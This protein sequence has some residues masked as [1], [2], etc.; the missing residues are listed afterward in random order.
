MESTPSS[1]GF[2]VFDDGANACESFHLT[3]LCGKL[4]HIHWTASR[5]ALHIHPPKVI[6][7]SIY[8]YMV[9]TNLIV[10][11]VDDLKESLSAKCSAWCQYTRNIVLYR[12]ASAFIAFY[13]MQCVHSCAFMEQKTTG[14]SKDKSNS[15]HL[16]FAWCLPVWVF[17]KVSLAQWYLTYVCITFEKC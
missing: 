11:L 1:H 16:L 4:T 6:L 9:D 17:E 3:Q 2:F 7:L 8:I 13:P 10:T 5:T 12:C 15:H 14:N